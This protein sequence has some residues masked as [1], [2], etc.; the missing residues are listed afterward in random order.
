VVGWAVFFGFMRA[1]ALHTYNGR[2]AQI[3]FL[4][5]RLAISSRVA[6]VNVNL[7]QF[8]LLASRHIVEDSLDD[9]RRSG[10]ICAL[11]FGHTAKSAPM[12]RIVMN[13]K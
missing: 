13:R 11:P 9:G 6:R 10:I 4:H 2:R 3:D 7:L 1:L 8:L 12:C 5:S